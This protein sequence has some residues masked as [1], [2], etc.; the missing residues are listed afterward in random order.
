MLEL[1]N[2]LKECCSVPFGCIIK[3]ANIWLTKCLVVIITS[4][5]ML[6]DVAL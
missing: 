2:Q 1:L 3:I 5:S 4:E 6:V